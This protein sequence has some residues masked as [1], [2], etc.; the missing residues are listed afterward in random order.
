MGQ[1]TT[2]TQDLCV[3]TTTAG[4]HQYSNTA[5]DYNTISGMVGTNCDFILNTSLS[6]DIYNANFLVTVHV[7]SLYHQYP[8]HPHYCQYSYAAPVRKC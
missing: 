5:K 6:D 1:E 4:D 8:Q 7:P 3:A 2:R